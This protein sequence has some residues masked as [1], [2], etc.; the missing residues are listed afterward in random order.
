MVIVHENRWL[1]CSNAACDPNGDVGA[2][3]DRHCWFIPCAQTLGSECPICSRVQTRS[4]T[5]SEPS[6]STDASRT[7]ATIHRVASVSSMTSTTA[8]VTPP[9]S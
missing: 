4:R 7:V 6:H 9:G 3:F 2:L 5:G 1:T 8:L